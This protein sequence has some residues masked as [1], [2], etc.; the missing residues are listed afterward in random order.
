MED[1]PTPSALSADEIPFVVREFAAGARNA[2][3]AGCDGVELHAPTGGWWAAG[4][5]IRSDALDPA[6]IPSP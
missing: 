4:G 5:Q 1:Y 3:E 2:L 6:W